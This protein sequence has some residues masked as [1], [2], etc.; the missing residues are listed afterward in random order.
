MIKNGITGSPL[1]AITAGNNNLNASRISL[2][3]TAANFTIVNFP[4]SRNYAGFAFGESLTNSQMLDDYNIW[5]TFQ[6]DFNGRQ[7]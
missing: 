7:V 6:T 4:T 2:G 1:R 3:G 5:Q